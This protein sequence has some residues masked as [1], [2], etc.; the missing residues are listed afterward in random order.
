MGENLLLYPL[1]LGGVSIIASIV[2]CMFVK[3][4][5]GGK[6]MSALYRGLAVAGVLALVAYPDHLLA[7][8]RRR[9]RRQDFTTM[10]MFGCSVVGA[11]DRCAGVDHRYYTGTRYAPVKHVAAACQTGHATNIIAGIGVSMKPARCR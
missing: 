3:A 1:A 8:R 10:S 4:T 6:I 9:R 2:G 7:D 5:E 11:A